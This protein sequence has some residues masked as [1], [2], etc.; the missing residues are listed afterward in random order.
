MASQY[1]DHSFHGK[2]EIPGR[3]KTLILANE[4]LFAV[5]FGESEAVTATIR[6]A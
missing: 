4:T 6:F 2:S 5:P 3:P 1:A